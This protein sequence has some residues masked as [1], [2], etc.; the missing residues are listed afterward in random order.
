[1]TI[2]RFGTLT[3]DQARKQA[4]KILAS[5]AVGNDPAAELQAK[6]REIKMDALIDLYEDM[7]CVVQRGIP[8]GRADEASHQ[9]LHNGAVCGTTWCRSSDIGELRKSTPET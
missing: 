2:A 7:G 9:N 3:A 4:K 1:M 5:V 8:A 6:R